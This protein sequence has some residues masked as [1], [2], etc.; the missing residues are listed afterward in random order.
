MIVLR[1]DIQTRSY[2]IAC[3]QTLK[4]SSYIVSTM[5]LKVANTMQLKVANLRL[6][7]LQGQNIKYSMPS[8]LSYSCILSV[9][10]ETVRRDARQAAMP[11]QILWSS[12][13]SG[14]LDSNGFVALGL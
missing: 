9:A 6:V 7:G 11:S 4:T 13:R 12:L 2:T 1:Y 14:P 5:Q 10:L 3:L 8:I